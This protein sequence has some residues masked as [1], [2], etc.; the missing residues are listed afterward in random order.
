[1]PF[2][3]VGKDKYRSPSGKIFTRDQVKLYYAN[4]GSFPHKKKKKKKH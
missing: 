2:K 4:N 3:K 1:M